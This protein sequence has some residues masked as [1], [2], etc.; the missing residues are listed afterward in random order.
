MRDMNILRSHIK[1]KKKYLCSRAYRPTNEI[2]VG[3]T[4]NMGQYYHSENLRNR[5]FIN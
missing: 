1:I 5:H 3:L 4:I 2:K